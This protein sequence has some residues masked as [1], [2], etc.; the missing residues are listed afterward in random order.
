MGLLAQGT[1]GG[2]GTAPVL[3][4]ALLLETALPLAPAVLLAGGGGLLIGG[5]FAGIAHDGSRSVPYTALLVPPAVYTCCLLAAATSL[6]LLR[7]SVR[8]AELRY[9]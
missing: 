9:V 8:P 6:P 3:G 2:Y 1:F 7:R 4:R 5:W